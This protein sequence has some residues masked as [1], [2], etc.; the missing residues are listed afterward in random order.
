MLF[1]SK[2]NTRSEDITRLYDRINDI[3]AELSKLKAEQERLDQGHRSLRGK[4]NRESHTEEENPKESSFIGAPS[5]T[6]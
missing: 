2:K 1:K 4:I 6:H 3:Y 5:F